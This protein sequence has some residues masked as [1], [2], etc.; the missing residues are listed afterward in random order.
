MPAVRVAAAVE[1]SRI[2]Q[3]FAHGCS[4]VPMAV[5]EREAEEP[6]D[7][8]IS[9]SSWAV[10]EEELRIAAGWSGLEA[11]AVLIAKQVA[12]GRAMES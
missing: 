5:I 4:V 3:D 12:T 8:K 1:V 9:F 6:L 2:C 11:P 7:S 10:R